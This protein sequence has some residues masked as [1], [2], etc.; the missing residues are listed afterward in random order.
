MAT[1]TGIAGVTGEPIRHPVDAV[2][3][4]AV[5]RC[6]FWV[7]DR[8]A[9]HARGTGA[10]LTKPWFV[11]PDAISVVP[12]VLN[13]DDKVL[14]NDQRLDRQLGDQGVHPR[15]RGGA[16]GTR[17]PDPHTASARREV[18]SGPRRSVPC[19]EVSGA[20]GSVRSCS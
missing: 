13:P 19:G 4:D 1:R 11:L 7:G 12:V 14:T 5:H 17:T 18:R 6:A 20:L 16:E 15:K 8:A 2:A 3:Q 10:W 9:V